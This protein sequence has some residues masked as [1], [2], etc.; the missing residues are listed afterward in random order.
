MENSSD[1][2]E[3]VMSQVR[4]GFK[5]EFAYLME[6]RSIGGSKGLG[7]TQTQT[8]KD[9]GGS[10]SHGVFENTIKK[11]QKS[12]S[13]VG[14]KNNVEE[15]FP[16]DRVSSNDGKLMD[17]NVVRSGEGEQSNDLMDN[18]TK[19]GRDNESMSTSVE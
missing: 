4:P 18:P 17:N 10:S 2:E 9:R 5:R 11:R 8:K 14:Q 3:F 13:L 7:Q 15:R 19:I 1:L 12:S 6:A 16:K